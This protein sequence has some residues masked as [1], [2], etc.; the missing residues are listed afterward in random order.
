VDKRIS[1]SDLAK[2]AAPCKTEQFLADATGKDKSTAKRWLKGTSRVPDR[3]VYAV[4]ADIFA[5][6]G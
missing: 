6:I 4:F 2:F 3:A 5:R 1:F